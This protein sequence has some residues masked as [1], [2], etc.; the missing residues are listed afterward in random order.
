MSINPD[1]IRRAELDGIEGLTTELTVRETEDVFG[2]PII[3]SVDGPGV[4]VRV[5]RALAVLNPRAADTIAAA[6][7]AASCVARNDIDPNEAL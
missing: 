4:Y 5:G 2:L 1:T 7:L 3:V 6:L